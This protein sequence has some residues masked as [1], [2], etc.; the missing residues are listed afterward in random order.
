MP[1]FDHWWQAKGK[2]LF[3]ERLL[4]PAVRE[5]DRMNMRLSAGTNDHLLLE[6]PL[7]LTEAT[8]VRQVKQI[9]RDH[10]SREVERRS[11]ALRPLAKFTGIRKDLLQIAHTTWQMHWET[12]DPTQSIPGVLSKIRV[13]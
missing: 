13:S 2:H 3:A 4:P 7:N 8:I 9:L 11:S 1:G 5:L 10:P 6:I 12:R